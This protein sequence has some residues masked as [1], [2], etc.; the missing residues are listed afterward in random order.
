MS[1]VVFRISFWG[2][3]W[4]LLHCMTCSMVCVGVCAKAFIHLRP[5]IFYGRSCC[6]HEPGILTVTSDFW[7]EYGGVMNQHHT[8]RKDSICSQ[9]LILPLFT[10][11]ESD[12]SGQ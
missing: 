7:D 5:L 2:D 9:D 6:S 4:H 10:I 12:A 8:P 1:D 3:E 11:P